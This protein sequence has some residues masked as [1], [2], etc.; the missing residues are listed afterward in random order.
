MRLVTLFFFLNILLCT[1]AYC[2]KIMK[3]NIQGNERIDDATIISYLDLEKNNNVDISDLNIMFKELFSTELFSEITFNLNGDILIVKVKENPVINRIALEGNKRVKDDDLLPEILLKPRD[4]LTLNKVKNNLQKILG[5]YRGNGRYAAVVKPKVIYLEQNRVDLV[6]EIEEGPLT[7]IGFIKFLGNSFFSDRKL[8]TEIL[9]KESRWWKVLSTGGKFDPDL[10]NFDQENLKR[11]YA[12][13]GFVDAN[14][15]TSIAE[16]NLQRDA[17]F[18]TFMVNEGERYRFGNISADVKLRGVD[19]SLIKDGIRFKKGS[20]FSSKRLDD[21]IVKITENIM[22]NGIP[23]ISVQPSLTRKQ[24]NTIDV[25]FNIIPAKK[26]YINKII[27]SGNT[28]TLDKVIRRKLRVAEGDAYNSVLIKRSRLL[29]NNMG[30]FSKVEVA[31]QDSTENLNSVDINI[32]VE[33]TSTGE[34]SLGGGYSSS[35]GAQATIGLSENNLFGKGQRLKLY[36]LTSER[37]NRADFSFTEPFFL[38]R[39]VSLKTDIFTTVKEYRESYYDNETDGLGLGLGYNTGEYGRQSINYSLENRSIIAYS[40]ASASVKSEEGDNI[41]SIISLNHRVDKTNSRVD[42]SDGWY[43]SNQIGLAGIGGDKR[44]LRFGASAAS[45]RKILDE[46]LTFSLI[47]KSGYILGIDQN[48]DISD[49]FI[50]GDNSFVGFKNAGLGPRDVVT[51]QAL[52][53]N[54]Y[55]TLTPEIKF[56]LGL[57]KELGMRGRFFAT[58]GSLSSIDTNT[59]NYYDDSNIRLTTGAGV[60]WQSPFGPIRLD[61]SHAILKEDYDKTETFSFNIGQLF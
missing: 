41:L 17:F 50:L 13:K 11:F 14:I 58:A 44:Y 29:I 34:F 19:K 22:K 9:T 3:I 47:G 53:G 16:L 30:H 32:N 31:E 37:Q 56:D 54:L 10:L 26:N 15:E 43:T 33:E 25:I 28:R 5:I 18:I 23:F 21:A 42:P 38:N 4:I 51:D 12:N 35:N 2:N 45:F 40:G 6:F 49:R 20:W 7:K 52:G 36:F 48:I 46:R 55:Y 57:P 27:I 59:T 39:D 8:K 1:N 61:Y 60:L 24:D